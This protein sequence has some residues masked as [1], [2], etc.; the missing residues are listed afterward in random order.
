[1]VLLGWHGDVSL[2][3]ITS[4]GPVGPVGTWLTVYRVPVMTGARAAGI[5]R[6]EGESD[7]TGACTAEI[8]WLVTTIQMLLLNHSRCL[9]G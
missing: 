6:L 4:R 2:Q 8:A 7:L 3:G 1:M 5:A 9:S